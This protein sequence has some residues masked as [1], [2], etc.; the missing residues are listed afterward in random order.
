M[1]ACYTEA[2]A[3]VLGAPACPMPGTGTTE[4]SPAH[5]PLA[6]LLQM[7]RGKAECVSGNWGLVANCGH[8]NWECTDP[9]SFCPPQGQDWSH[10]LLFRGILATRSFRWLW[11]ETQPAAAAWGPWRRRRGRPGP[12]GGCRSRRRTSEWSG[13]CLGCPEGAPKEG[14]KGKPPCKPM[15]NHTIDVHGGPLASFLGAC[16]EMLSAQ[17]CRTGAVV[18]CGSGGL[19]ELP[20]LWVTFQRWGSRLHGTSRCSRVMFVALHRP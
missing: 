20:A 16:L 17:E 15:V 13:V 18:L 6:V 12:C 8:R 2:P 1:P 5:S 14:D 11:A 10:V 19:S 3:W 7:G 9:A 4:D